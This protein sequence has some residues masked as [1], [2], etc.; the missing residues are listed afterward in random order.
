VLITSPHGF[1]RTVAFAPDDDPAVIAK[2]VQETPL[3]NA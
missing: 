2:R 3:A 1:D